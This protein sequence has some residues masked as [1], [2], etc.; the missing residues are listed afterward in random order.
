MRCGAVLDSRFSKARRH[1]WS[2]TFANPCAVN[3]PAGLV[4][5][6]TFGRGQTIC[7]K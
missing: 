5:P 2:G 3:R 1:D 4:L 6:V 7:T